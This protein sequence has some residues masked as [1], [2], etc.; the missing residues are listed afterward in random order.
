MVTSE[1]I[2]GRL[3]KFGKRTEKPLPVMRT[4]NDRVP[5]IVKIRE[6]KGAQPAPTNPRAGAP[7]L[8]KINTQFR[9]TFSATPRYI[10]SAGTSGLDTASLQLFAL[11]KTSAGTSDKLKIAINGLA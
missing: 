3:S 9:K 4:Q 10:I 1:R 5:A 11:M 6:M 7:R 2:V 8:P